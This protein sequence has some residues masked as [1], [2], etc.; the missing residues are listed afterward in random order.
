M[1][2]YMN[3]MA[4]FQED[5]LLESFQD[6]QELNLKTKL[7]MRSLASSFRTPEI[8]K[9]YRLNFIFHRLRL[10]RRANVYKN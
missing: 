8:E 1:E 3:E 5:T 9:L 10:R 4:A 2:E 6:D 7:F